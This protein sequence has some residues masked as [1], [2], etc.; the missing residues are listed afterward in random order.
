MAR[1][2]LVKLVVQAVVQERDGDGKVVGE[3]VSQPQ[4]CF[5]LEQVAS[6][7]AQAL[8]E[9]DAFNAEQ[10]NRAQRRGRLQKEAKT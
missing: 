10:P 5:D 4:S 3:L 1:R 2:E 8:V 9:V 7:H 6:V